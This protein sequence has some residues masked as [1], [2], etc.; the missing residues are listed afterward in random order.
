M[1]CGLHSPS[2]QNNP[3]N[4]SREYADTERMGDDEHMKVSG[5]YL[6]RLDLVVNLRIFHMTN[7]IPDVQM[8]LI[9][10]ES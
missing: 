6:Q 7:I 3:Q 10:L 8:C 9:F 4:G 5:A 1:F 2:L